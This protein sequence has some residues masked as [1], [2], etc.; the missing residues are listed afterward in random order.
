MATHFIDCSVS[1]V[2]N[3]YGLN[4]EINIDL[5]LLDVI[6]ADDIEFFKKIWMVNMLISE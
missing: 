6:G 4:T 1:L 2:Q 5:S 3:N